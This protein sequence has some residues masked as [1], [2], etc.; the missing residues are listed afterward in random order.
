MKGITDIDEG[1]IRRIDWQELLP[2]SMLFRI[3]PKSFNIL[4]IISMTFVIFFAMGLATKTDT[5]MAVRPQ[6]LKFASFSQYPFWPT[7]LCWPITSIW[8]IEKSNIF[9]L[10]HSVS[11]YYVKRIFN[12]TSL[13][14]LIYAFFGLILARKTAV[15]LASTQRSSLWNSVCYACLNFKSFLLAVGLLICGILLFSLIFDCLF[16]FL[17]KIPLMET[18]SLITTPVL[19]AFYAGAL[20]FYYGLI[21]SLP[22]IVAAI[23]TNKSDGFDAVSR[24]FS[25][26]CQRP[27]HFIFYSAIAI[28]LGNL[29]FAIVNFIS[30]RLDLLFLTHRQLFN[31]FWH[32]WLVLL[33]Q[34]YLS[35]W[36]IISMTTIYFLLRRSVD[37]TAFDIVA[38]DSAQKVH[39]LKPILKDAHSA[40]ITPTESNFSSESKSELSTNEDK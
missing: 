38:S 3:F 6:S 34:G 15:S 21:L 7:S 40:P 17:N 5:Y 26:L 4:M 19:L 8:E 31:S 11:V 16:Y 12:F 37:G 25:Y 2:V 32:Y 23:A 24:S 20:L 39:Q 30:C 14:I 1:T 27:L 29:G 13:E 10:N 9:N 35:G 36:F 28:L 22:F 18:F 33:P